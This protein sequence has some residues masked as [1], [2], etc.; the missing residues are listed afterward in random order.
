MKKDSDPPTKTEKQRIFINK[1]TAF[2][3]ALMWAAVIFALSTGNAVQPPRL[4]DLLEPDKVAHVGA[5][6]LLGLLLLWGT[7]R[8]YGL[9]GYNILF[10]I[11]LAS[12]YGAAME[13]VQWQ[14]YP[15]RYFEVYDIIANC[16]GASLSGLVIKIL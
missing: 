4:T 2:L 3:P 13:W 9:S 5:Y 6:G 12:L 15:S 1:A 14:F 10:I 7:K 16:V 8:T 11:L